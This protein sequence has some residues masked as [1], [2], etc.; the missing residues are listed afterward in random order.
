MKR[1]R[2]VSLLVVASS[3]LATTATAQDPEPPID[4]TVQVDADVD[5]NVDADVDASVNAEADT[6][7]YFSFLS[8]LVALSMPHWTVQAGFPA[9]S[10]Q[11]GIRAV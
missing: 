3:L 7:G 9:N 2:Y 6:E 10:A 11:I 5:A 8:R 1:A 4:G